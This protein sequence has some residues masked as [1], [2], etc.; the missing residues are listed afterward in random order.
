MAYHLILSN[1]LS[2][3]ANVPDDRRQTDRRHAD[4]LYT[5]GWNV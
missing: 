4:I 1:G 3:C 2:R 5:Y